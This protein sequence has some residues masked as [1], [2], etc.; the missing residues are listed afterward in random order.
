MEDLPE[1]VNAEVYD[2]IILGDWVNQSHL[3]V[4]VEVVFPDV[5]SEEE[6]PD[7][8]ELFPTAEVVS[9]LAVEE[10]EE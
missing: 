7:R 3:S 1:D 5:D 2:V 10:V 4:E 6:L 8:D 9:F